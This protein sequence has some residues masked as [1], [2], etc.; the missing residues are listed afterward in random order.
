MQRNLPEEPHPDRWSGL[1]QRAVDMR[2]NPTSAEK[3]MWAALRNEQLDG[4]KFR[5]QHHIQQYLVDLSCF[6]ARL[7]I[8]IDGPIHDAQATKDAHRQSVIESFGYSVLRFSNEE[9]LGNLP[10]VLSRILEALHEKQ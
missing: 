5:R 8:E 7:V 6:K 4:F 10:N 2:R 1:P 9:V 3:T